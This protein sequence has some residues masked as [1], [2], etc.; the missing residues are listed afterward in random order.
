[1]AHSPTDDVH[2]SHVAIAVTDLE[3]S[4]RF[5]TEGLGFETGRHSTPA[6]RS[7]R[8]PRWSRRYR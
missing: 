5:Y 1:M 2:V 7:P 3:V 4:T 8:C 6:T